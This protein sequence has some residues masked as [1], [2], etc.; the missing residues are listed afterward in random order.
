MTRPH[1]VV[2]VSA[3]LADRSGGSSH[4]THVA[5]NLDHEGEKLVSAEEILHQ[6]LHAGIVLRNAAAHGRSMFGHDARPLFARSHV[7]HIS[8]NV[9]SDVRN[10]ADKTHLESRSGDLLFA[11]H[12]PETVF[13]VVV[14]DGRQRLNRTVAAVVVGKQQAVGRNDLARTSGTEDHDGVLE[15]GFVDAVNLLGRKFAPAGLHLLDIH[16]LKVGQQPHS[17]V[18]RSGQR[19]AR[20]GDQ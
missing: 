8:Q 4:Q 17:L 9:G 14:F 11:R 18:G 13:Q 15:R 10:L 12:G 5:E 7:G 3:E 20:R 16:F 2:G 1:P 19:G 6:H